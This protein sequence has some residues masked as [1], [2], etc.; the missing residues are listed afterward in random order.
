MTKTTARTAFDTANTAVRS[1]AAAL[2]LVVTMGLMGGLN[3]VA[4]QQ[5][6]H[7]LA[8]RS[9]QGPTQMVLITGHRPARA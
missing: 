4:D 8:A 1:T 6:D 2:A 9:A 3:A 7:V 5:Y